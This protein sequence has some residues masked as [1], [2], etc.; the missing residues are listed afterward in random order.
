MFVIRGSELFE[1]FELSTTWLAQL[2]S[3]RADWRGPADRWTGFG[4]TR[5]AKNS[6]RGHFG[7]TWLEKTR[8]GVTS[9]SLRGGSQNLDR[10]VFSELFGPPARPE[11]GSGSLR[12]HLSRENSVRGQF[13]VTSG[14]LRGHFGVTGL[15][16]NSARGHFGATSGSLGSRKLGSG[17]LRSHLA[18]ENS[19]RGHF[20]AT[21]RE[22]TR[23]GFTS[24][25]LGSRR[26]GSGSLRGH[27]ARGSSARGHFEDT[28]L[29]KTRLWVAS[30]PLGSRK[31]GS[32][33]F[34]AT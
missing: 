12:S 1:L 20:E 31:L 33:S 24:R 18:R 3:A 8:L 25:P 7:A 26:L 15:A 29:G 19:A 22:K 6:A 11:L 28:W 21:W 34:E 16:Q 32:G 30:R 17:S 5:L 14:S 23:L 10:R 2:G 9:G 4:V 27:M 13:G